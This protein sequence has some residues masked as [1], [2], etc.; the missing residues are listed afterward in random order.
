LPIGLPIETMSGTTPWRWKPHICPPVR[1]KP[2]CTS[3]ARNR[4]PAARIA[5]TA[6][7]RKPGGSARPVGGEDRVDDQ[8]G[9]ADALIA[10]R[11]AGGGD[12]GGEALRDALRVVG[13]GRRRDGEDAGAGGDGGADRHDIIDAVA[14]VTP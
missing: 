1:P 6:G 12:G 3:S 9:R 2:G 14:S 8:Q 4:P 5:A 11:G 10:H 13:G 7:A